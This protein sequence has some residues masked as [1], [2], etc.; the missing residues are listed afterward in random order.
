MEIVKNLLKSNPDTQAE[1]LANIG[2]SKGITETP[3]I[4]LNSSGFKEALAETGLRKALEEEGINSK[5]IA[6]KI[7]V[8]LEASKPI[9][10]NNNS[11]GEIEQVGEEIDYT[12]VDKGLKHATAIYGITDP[13]KPKEAN[14]YNFFF[15][16][17]FQKNIKNYDENFKNQILNAQETKTN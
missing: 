4:V 13:E 11:T 5:K 10:K 2:Y 15:E 3:S 16:P 14:V 17:T 1:V 12:A 7:N 6:E 8:L 9:F